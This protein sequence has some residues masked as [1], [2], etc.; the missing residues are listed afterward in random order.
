MFRDIFTL[1]SIRC[2]KIAVM[3]SIILFLLQFLR[4]WLSSV[5]LVKAKKKADKRDKEEGSMEALAVVTFYFKV[6]EVQFLS[7]GIWKL[8]RNNYRLDFFFFRTSTFL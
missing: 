3:K 2:G 8:F 5:E 4:H 7:A 6:I 1:A